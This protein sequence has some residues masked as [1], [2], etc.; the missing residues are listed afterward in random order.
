M[1]V[2]AR[3]SCR[4]SREY[5]ARLRH[6]IVLCRVRDGRHSSRNC[7]PQRHCRQSSAQPKQQ[8]RVVAAPSHCRIFSGAPGLAQ[9]SAYD[10][11]I[12]PPF[13]NDVSSAAPAL[14]VDD[15]D[16][17][18]VAAQIPR[19]RDADDARAEHENAHR[20]R[21]RRRR[22]TPASADSSTGTQLQNRLRSP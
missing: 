1:P 9:G 20:W 4:Q 8:R 13:A 10:A 17:V 6:W 11:E 14:P 3:S 12:W 16:F 22:A 18:T 19:R 5:S 7:R 2:A 15:R 21:L